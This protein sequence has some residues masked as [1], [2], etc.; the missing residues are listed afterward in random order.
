[1]KKLYIVSGLNAGLEIIACHKFINNLWS[2]NTSHYLGAWVQTEVYS[3]A[4]S[5]VRLLE[6]INSQVGEKYDEFLVLYSGDNLYLFK[7][8][9]PC[10]KLDLARFMSGLIKT[11]GGYDTPQQKAIADCLF[12][13]GLQK[14]VTDL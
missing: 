13:G 4:Q 2:L 1:M 9:L 11:V 7:D 6:I 10:D 5:L 8:N 14:L 12:L 3:P